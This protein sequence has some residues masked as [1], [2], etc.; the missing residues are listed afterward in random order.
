MTQDAI[1]ESI[2]EEFSMFDDWLDKYDYLIS[3]SDSLPEIS[4]DKRTEKYLIEGCQSR[5]WVAAE[6]REG[7]VFYTADSDAIITKGIIALLIR[8]MNGRSAAEAAAIDLYFIDAIGLGENL[9]PT[10]SN[11]LRAMIQQMKLYA[12]V[13]SKQSQN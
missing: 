10:R 4:A 8:V 1:Q 9:S 13:F 11:G 7:K 6:M 5:V 3:L 2:I 12:L